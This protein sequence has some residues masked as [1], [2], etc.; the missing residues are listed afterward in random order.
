[1]PAYGEFSDA[2][3]KLICT[4]AKKIFISYRHQ[5]SEWVRT[6]LYPVLSAGGADIVIDYKLFEAGE[7]IRRQMKAAQVKADIHLLVFT[8]DYFQSDYC[9][10]E[11]KRAFALDPDFS[12]GLVL[13]VIL[14]RCD[15]PREIKKHQPLYV[16]LTGKRQYDSEA[17][18]LIMK[19]CGAS[20]GASP[21]D[22]LR[23]FRSLLKNL[24]DKHS[25][26][27]T[28][29]GNGVAWRQLLK[30]LKLALPPLGVVDLHRGQT[31]TRRLLIEE[32][33]KV[34]NGYQGTLPRHDLAEFERVLLAQPHT[35]LALTHFDTIKEKKDKNFDNNFFNCLRFLIM[36]ERKLTLLIGSDAPFA[37]LLP[38]NHRL[39][40]L[41]M[42]TVELRG[43]G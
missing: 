33:L 5:Q 7:A 11:M 22:W 25:V 6:T 41:E 10:E 4:M 26:N 34:C 14:E 1:M 31:E 2:L 18:N 8:P 13:P 30:Q 27:F 3:T 42:E 23:A 32:I 28:V 37:T 15:L 17:W 12:K 38:K 16:D 39:S 19:R 24:Q 40:Y 9:V 36:D 35:W 43:N 20:L 21:V 29:K